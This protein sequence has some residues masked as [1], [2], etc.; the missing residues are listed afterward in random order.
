MTDKVNLDRASLPDQIKEHLLE[1][2][3]SGVLKPGDRL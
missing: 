3:T 1:Q 2:I